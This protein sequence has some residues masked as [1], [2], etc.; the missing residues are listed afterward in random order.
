M[1]GGAAEQARCTATVRGRVQGV[2]FRAFTAQ[3][4]RRLGLSGSVGNLPDGRSVLVEAEGERAALETLLGRLRA[5]PP[6]ARVDDVDV[7]W[8]E[9][10]GGEPGFRVVH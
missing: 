1:A 9:P 6:L 3:L 10:Q 2:N 4:A 7:T 8:S 5:G